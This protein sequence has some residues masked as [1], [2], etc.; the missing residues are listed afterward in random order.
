MS[1]AETAKGRTRSAYA[2][3]VLRL[4]RLG[5]LLIVALAVPAAAVAADSPE[6]TALEE[7]IW[8]DD[9]VLE[10][11][12]IHLSSTW[13][14]DDFV[15]VDVIS[16]R[17]DAR[18]YMSERYGSRVRVTVIAK[19]LYSQVKT[20]WSKYRVLGRGRRIRIVWGT[21]SAFK[22][23]RVRKR[24]GPRRVVLTVVERA[25]N[26]PV[27]MAGQ[28]RAA[29]IRLRR[30]LGDRRVFDGSTGRPRQRV[31]RLRRWHGF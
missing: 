2:D 20:A 16:A 12:G 27:T 3:R 6:A 30:P 8:K 18:A 21:N 29:T 17:R 4:A 19:R 14:K 23:L 7:R 25:P 1:S 9:R 31:K 26:G 22:F 11:A 10:N 28:T 13:V 5:L 15:H 24:E